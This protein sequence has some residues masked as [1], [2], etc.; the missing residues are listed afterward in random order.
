MSIDVL[1]KPEKEP[2]LLTGPE[3]DG[4]LA[5]HAAETTKVTAAEHKESLAKLPDIGSQKEFDDFA[6]AGLK[7]ELDE[8]LPTPKATP[9]G[10]TAGNVAVADTTQIHPAA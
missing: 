1:Q 7:N 10:E 9:V 8:V 2:K 4:I 5:A 6:S 3:I